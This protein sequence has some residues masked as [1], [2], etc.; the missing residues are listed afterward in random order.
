LGGNSRVLGNIEL[1]IPFPGFEKG[2]ST[3][4]SGF[5]DAGAVYGEGDLPGSAGI[6]SSVGTAFT[7]L[8]PVG[9]LKFSYA[10]PINRQEV[11]R[12]ENFQFTLGQIF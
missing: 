3:R 2:R 11:D 5:I 10:W 8:S 7:W 9:P 12:V 6:R 4:L 1:L